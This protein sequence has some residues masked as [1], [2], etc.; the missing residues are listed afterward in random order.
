MKRLLQPTVLGLVLALAVFVS[1]PH[2]ATAQEN[3]VRPG[4]N[5]HFE[6]PDVNEFIGK[7]E[8]ESREIFA[9]RNEIVAACKLKP[10]MVVA[11]I[12][13][14]TGLFT[15]LFAKEVGPGGQVMAVDIAPKFIQHIEKTC[16]EQC[17]RNVVGVVCKPDSVELPANSVDLA[18]ICD[19]YHHFEFPYKT[20]ASLHR[21]LR[22]GGQV[23]LLDFHRIP[24]KSSI[25]VLGHVRAGQEVFTREIKA[26]GFKQL[27]DVALLKENYFVR[28]QKVESSKDQERNS[29]E[30]EVK[31]LEEI[32]RQ[33]LPILR[34]QGTPP[35]LPITDAKLA[36]TLR[37][38]QFF[39]LG[40]RQYPVVQAAPEPLK[41]RNLFAVGK[42]ARVLHLTD[43]RA[44]EEFFGNTL[45]LITDEKSAKSS[46]EAWLR[47]TEEFK[48]DGFFKFSVP[49][50]SLTAVHS[51]SGWRAS[52]KAIVTQGGKGEIIADLS[53]TE[54]GKL[55][56]VEE[57]N[58]VKA[59][60][61]PICQAT[62][63]LDS[64][65]SVRRMAEKDILV[66]GRAARE[67]LDEQRT[68]APPELKQAIDRIWR[69][70]VDEGW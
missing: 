14:G 54:A 69:R 11:D 64:D 59:G 33:K 7:F 55:A 31:K 3:S 46:A 2:P 49:G 50:E 35:L 34:N 65:D 60:V 18:F 43:I 23:V 37:A 47:L 13:A 44:L 32:V 36:Q 19:T 8:V 30:D 28:F 1:H 10:G 51:E 25:W 29:T 48:Q 9:K 56:K 4:I 67:Y 42:N 52:G 45:G 41:T 27:E 22:T 63:L 15:R 20:M 39:V 16:Q 21:A 38:Y 57:K 40:F 62:K 24:G 70:I 61:R 68:K 6:N 58:T 17:L 5:Q 66:M 26:A 12:G 53:F